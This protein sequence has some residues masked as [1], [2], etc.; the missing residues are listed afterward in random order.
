MPLDRV[1]GRGSPSFP[2]RAVGVPCLRSISRIGALSLTVLAFGCGPERPEGSS[3]G[4][5]TEVFTV[6]VIQGETREELGEIIDLEVLPD[7]SFLVMERAGRVLW[8][9]ADG[10]PIDAID[11]RGQGPGELLEPQTMAF[12]APGTLLVV[13]TRNNRFGYYDM[14]A[15]GFRH[16]RSRRSLSSLLAAAGNIC[17]G[18]GR[19]F[20]RI[21]RD[22]NAIHELGEDGSI[23]H[24]FGSVQ[25]AAESDFGSF[26]SLVTV[27]KNAGRLLCVSDPPRL[28]SVGRYLPRIESFTLDGDP[29][30]EVDV[31]DVHPWRLVPVP[32]ER[33][34]VRY[35]LHPEGSRRPESVVKYDDES[36]LVQYSF[37]PERGPPGD[38]DFHGIDSRRFSL[39]T[40]EELERRTDLPLIAGTWEDR[41]YS[42]RNKPF[43][44]VRVLAWSD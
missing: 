33:S 17:Q 22:G 11:D 4:E 34:G 5:L 31:V 19:L 39:T 26:A 2:R 38:R 28:I 20:L 14:S 9:S 42:Y 7:G 10:E 27:V 6:G 40:G 16:V 36:I 35:E 44:Q 43:P 24:S 30:W 15:G 41:F 37:W 8:F 23:V 21:A 29:A 3:E 25:P 32:G 13:D 12:L 1:R 18:D